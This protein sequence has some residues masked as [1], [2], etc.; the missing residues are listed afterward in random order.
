MFYNVVVKKVPENPVEKI[1]AIRSF[2][3]PNLNK[4]LDIKRF[5]INGMPV[6]LDSVELNHIASLIGGENISAERIGESDPVAGFDIGI[7]SIPP[8]NGKSNVGK[9]LT[10]LEKAVKWY[11]E[12][13][14]DD[15]V[16]ADFIIDVYAKLINNAACL[17]REAYPEPAGSQIGGEP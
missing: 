14:I 13:S 11:S 15:K 2:G 16:N 7:N 6:V 12:L 8:A 1:R 5:V 9:E 17:G 3:L 4:L 10:R